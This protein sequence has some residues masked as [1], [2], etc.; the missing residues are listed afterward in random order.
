MMLGAGPALN[1]AALPPFSFKVP[2]P[3]TF[4]LAGAHVP[5][6]QRTSK[7]GRPKGDSAVQVS[8]RK[9][10]DPLLSSVA[11]VASVIKSGCTCGGCGDTVAA[12]YDGAPAGVRQSASQAA[13]VRLRAPGASGHCPL[14][15]VD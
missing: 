12:A 11:G 8:Q 5:K 9:V 15:L 13:K 3:A 6:P 10:D 2:A 7:A 4:G 14:W 1:G